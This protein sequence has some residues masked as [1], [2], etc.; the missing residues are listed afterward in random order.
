MKRLPDVAGTV[1]IK[2]NFPSGILD[3][4][5]VDVVVGDGSLSPS[6][7]DETG[8]SSVVSFIRTLDPVPALHLSLEACSLHQHSLFHFPSG[9]LRSRFSVLL[10]V[11]CVLQID[12]FLV[13]MI[14]NTEY[15]LPL[16]N[17]LT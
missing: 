11:I 13:R 6:V 10:L 7:E 3:V 4:V 1:L 16:K 2:V 5:V 12:L 14:L 9:V 17:R 8:S 15:S